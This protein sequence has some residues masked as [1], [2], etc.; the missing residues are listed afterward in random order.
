MTDY[1]SNTKVTRSATGAEIER[2]L[3]RFGAQK[4]AAGWEQDNGFVT[5]VYAGRT[6]TI[7]VPMPDRGD[8]QYTHTPTTKVR[9]TAAAAQ[10]EYDKA[11]RA[12]W[13][14]LAL[15]IKAMLVA[16]SAGIFTFEEA[17]FGYTV[18]PGG[19]TVS[20]HLLPFVNHAIEEGHLP[21]LPA[22]M[23]VRS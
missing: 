13:R 22:S 8:R 17:F 5:F 18:L 6:V 20:Q 4:F 11:V 23:Q 21:A 14:A 10:A 2:T 15:V 3:V 16:V 7:R 1:A 12:R 19:A 9:R